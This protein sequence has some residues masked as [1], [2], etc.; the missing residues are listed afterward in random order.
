[1]SEKLANKVVLITGA[2]SGFGADAARL[3]ANEGC[4]VVLAARRMD[5]L[6]A[7]AE[8]IQAEGHKAFVVSLD[9][10]RTIPD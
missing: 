6:N 8:Q 1:M 7:L 9:V 10:S 5:R 4:I 3:F 2:S